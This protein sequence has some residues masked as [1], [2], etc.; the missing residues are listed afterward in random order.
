MSSNRAVV[1]AGSGRVEIR[2]IGWPRFQNPAGREIAHGVILKV[3]LT[4]ICCSD[5]HMIRGGSKLPAG[6]ALGHE[7]TGEVVETGH[8]VEYVKVGDLVSVPFNVACGRCRNCREGQTGLCLNVNPGSAGGV[9]GYVGMGGWIG[10]QAEYVMVPYADFNLLR[11]PD[12]TDAIARIRDLTCLT[13]ILPT[14]FNGAVTA[15]VEVGSTVYI[16]GA[17]PIGLAAAAAARL[18][19]ASAVLIGDTDRQRLAHARNVGFEPIDVG[20][21]D[22]LADLIANVLRKPEVDCVIDCSGFETKHRDG[23]GA[24]EMPA[25]LLTILRPAGATSTLNVTEDFG[26][27]EEAARRGWPSLRFGFGWTKSHAMHKGHMPVQRYNRQLMEMI[28]RGRLPIGDI[29]NVKIIKLTDAP[30][31]YRK[32]EAGA[33]QKFVI[34]PHGTVSGT[35]I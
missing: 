27:L 8:D 24:T 1:Y 20:H 35:N 9:Y 30:D 16:A 11:F 23:G 32:I 21:D 28:L 22:P 34:D 3:I 13:D 25:D 10:G 6:T 29:V 19:G 26:S 31:A 2:D 17:G 4:N 7:I 33:S 18:L 12:K 15:K 5:V 14:A